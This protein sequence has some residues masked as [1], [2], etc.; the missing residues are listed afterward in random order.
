MAGRRERLHDR[1]LQQLAKVV[2]L[3]PNEGGNGEVKGNLRLLR[4][5]DVLQRRVCTVQQCVLVVPGGGAL[6]L[7]E[8]ACE[9]VV[10]GVDTRIQ[11]KLG[12]NGVAE[13]VQG[14]LDLFKLLLAQLDDGDMQIHK[15]LAL[16]VVLDNV[17]QLLVKRERV[18]GALHLARNTHRNMNKTK[19]V[20]FGLKALDKVRVEGD[21]VVAR[22]ENGQR[23]KL[24]Q[25]HSQLMPQLAVVVFA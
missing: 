11:A 2:C 1:V 22:V 8:G 13:G 20:Q 18:R 9:L 6:C 19:P 17:A 7:V 14:L 15:Q 23:D 10:H 3:V 5:G 16:V 12:R 21:E 25:R 4:L 24:I